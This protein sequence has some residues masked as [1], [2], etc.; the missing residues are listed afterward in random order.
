[1]RGITRISVFAIALVAGRVDAGEILV[2]AAASLTDSL[3]EAGR[4][5]E[6]RSGDKIVFNFGASSE[7]VRQVE[8]GAPADLFLS[9][10][11]EKMDALERK[12]FIESDTR[13][14][15]LSNQ[16]VIVAARDFPPA[17][18][19]RS[20]LTGPDIKRIAVAEPETVP[21]GIYA[22]AFLR[23]QGVWGAVKRKII[24]VANVRAVL[25]TVESD[26]ADAG[27]VYKTDALISKRAKIVFT[28]PVRE[29]P[30]IV[31]PAAVVKG[32]RAARTARNFL[33]FLGSEEARGLFESYG[34]VVIERSFRAG[35]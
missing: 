16:L 14:N 23:R 5:H 25:A 24:P 27:F 3:R 33:A 11:L 20:L 18:T 30:P 13:I 31:Y 4:R 7:L 21:A 34:F 22:K 29:G 2:S 32:S 35:K 19:S 28:V 10:D 6:K 9:A 12:G 26:D 17:A 15:L 1:M 8:E